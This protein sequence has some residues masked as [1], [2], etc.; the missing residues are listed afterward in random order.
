MALMNAYAMKTPHA[1]VRTVQKR[2]QDMVLVEE[3][4]SK[5]ARVFLHVTQQNEQLRKSVDILTNDISYYW[6]LTMDER[7]KTARLVAS[8][9]ID[10]EV[11]SHLKT[12]VRKFETDQ[13]EPL[14]RD[15]ELVE[16]LDHQRWQLLDEMIFDLATVCNVFQYA[17]RQPIGKICDSAAKLRSTQELIAQQ[18][19]ANALVS[20]K[21][22]L[23]N[24]SEKSRN[25]LLHIVKDEKLAEKS[26]S[27]SQASASRQLCVE[28]V[29]KLDER[30]LMRETLYE[31]NC[32]KEAEIQEHKLKTQADLKAVTARATLLDGE[33]ELAR[34]GLQGILQK[35]SSTQARSSDQNARLHELTQRCSNLLTHNRKITDDIDDFREQE[36]NVK[37]EIDFAEDELKKAK[38]HVLSAQSI[39]TSLTD[40]IAAE[41]VRMTNTVRLHDEKQSQ[42]DAL[43]HKLQVKKDAVRSAI[44]E[45]SQR[46]Q[47]A[48][49][50]LPRARTEYADIRTKLESLRKEL[51]LAVCNNQHQKQRCDKVRI[52]AEEAEAALAAYKNSRANQYMRDIEAAVRDKQAKLQVLVQRCN[53]LQAKDSDLRVK[54]A[55]LATCSTAKNAAEIPLSISQSELDKLVSL[56]VE[57]Q[58]VS[59]EAAFQ[60]EILPQMQALE[61]LQSGRRLEIA[62]SHREA[63]LDKLRAKIREIKT[64]KRAPLRA[65]HL[66]SEGMRQVQRTVVVRS[67][68]NPSSSQA[69]ASNSVYAD[70]VK[71]STNAALSASTVT[72]SSTST[73]MGDW[74]NDADLW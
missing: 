43:Y 71:R 32:R 30:I 59:L 9:G 66:N 49:A 37:D 41:L 68:P 39:T 24:Q 3:H 53:E 16:D 4:V 36:L 56:S 74:F 25:E 47:S 62:R 33:L 50:E 54:Q 48:R 42:L 67:A 38:A 45:A 20:S 8:M 14:T 57:Q 64:G 63:G 23:E 55:A 72:H 2:T 21:L 15:F 69:A 18:L 28:E 1:A 13:V 6:K 44:L 27:K 51:E 29:E 60:L 7:H 12:L 65:Q 5:I 22:R 19:Q 35:I 58:R 34:V 26:T 70:G 52:A 61:V 46:A 31:Q 10:A 17:C 11:L 73:S 40:G